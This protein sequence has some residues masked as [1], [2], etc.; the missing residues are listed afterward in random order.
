MSTFTLAISRLTTSNLPWFIDLTFQVPMQYCFL[1]HRILLLSPVTATTGYCYC[2]GSLPS[3]FL[4]LFLHWSLVAYWAPND[5]RISSFGILSF[6]PF[7]L[8]MGFSRQEY[9]SGLLVPSPVDHIL[10]GLSTMTRLE[11]SGEITPERMKGWSQS[12]NN[13][14]LWIW[15]VIEARSNAVKSNMA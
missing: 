7:I 15:L 9:W 12:K 11:V 10:S 14:Q 2:F 3:F 5:L 13:T 6:C 1:Q 4:E 8:L